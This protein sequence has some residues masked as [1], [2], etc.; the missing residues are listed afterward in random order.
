MFRSK[1]EEFRSKNQG[2]NTLLSLDV[3]VRVKD[4]VSDYINSI[5]PEMPENS[6]DTY[7]GVGF[8][9]NDLLYHCR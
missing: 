4:F 7:C 6:I 2:E 8:K 3:F 1:L 9:R 5:L